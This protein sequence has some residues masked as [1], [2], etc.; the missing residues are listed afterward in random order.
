MDIESE[1]IHQQ[2]AETRSS[3]Q[4]KLES[5]EQQVTT[6]VQDATSA[7]GDT[8]EEVKEAV[9]ETVDAVKGA[10][11][12]TV[13]SVKST[14]DISQHIQAHPWAA[15]CGAAGA[16]FLATRWLLAEPNHQPVHPVSP[17]KLT[18]GSPLS[19]ETPRGAQGFAPIPEANGST[20][21]FS[22]EWQK[23][24]A[25]AIGTAGGLV[26]DVL[27]ASSP[28]AIAKQLQLLVDDIT[29]RLG[30]ELIEGPI[31]QPVRPEADT[32]FRTE[33]VRG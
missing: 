16:S 23:I 6:T 7:V 9:Q 32:T 26:R 25:L 31:L 21:F 11:Q 8:V 3:L 2:M 14:I 18:N 17:A 33:N 12:D 28:P 15:V 19:K 20:P 13:D 30:G 24:K 5:L 22:Q 27:A 1:V 10:V 4:D 29:T